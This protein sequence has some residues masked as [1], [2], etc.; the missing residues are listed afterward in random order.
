MKISEK[1]RTLKNFMQEFFDF[2][3]LV[4]NGFFKK[5]MKSNYKAQAERVCLFF[6]YETVYEYRAKE[7]R[8]HISYAE[9]H[10]PKDEPFVTVMPSIYES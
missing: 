5:E 8:C 7:I 9:G 10:R 1:D 4:K 2:N 6:G 3:E